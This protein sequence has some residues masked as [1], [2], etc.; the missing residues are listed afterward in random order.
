[1]DHSGDRFIDKNNSLARA[2]EADRK[3]VKTVVRKELGGAAKEEAQSCYN[4]KVR[5]RCDSFR[6]WRTG[7]TTGVV[8]VGDD[9]QFWC[10]KWTEDPATKVAAVS[11]KQAKSMMRSFRSGR[12]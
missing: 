10:E 11:D 3:K 8:T 7:G 4:C 2:Y 1:M 9:K 6:K 12:L 5:N